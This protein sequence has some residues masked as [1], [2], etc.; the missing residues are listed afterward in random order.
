M[1]VLDYYSNALITQKHLELK[2]L[3]N[4]RNL[5]IFT[6]EELKLYKKGDMRMQN[7][8]PINTLK[9]AEKLNIIL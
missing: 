9:V 6:I 8:K 5:Q 3:Y 7:C 4:I 2:C 1:F